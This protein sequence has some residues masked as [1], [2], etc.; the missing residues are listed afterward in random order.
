[1]EVVEDLKNDLRLRDQEYEKLRDRFERLQ[2]QQKELTSKLVVE[3]NSK[4][5]I[6]SKLNK[7]A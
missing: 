5:V 1:L 2:E 7:I 6:E 3:Q 4:Q